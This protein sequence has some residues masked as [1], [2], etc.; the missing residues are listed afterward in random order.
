VET[1][2]ILATHGYQST[3]IHPPCGSDGCVNHP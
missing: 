2:D 1:G 3:I